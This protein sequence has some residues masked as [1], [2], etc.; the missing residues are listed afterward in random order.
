[1]TV[2][3]I[4]GYV[5][6][7]GKKDVDEEWFTSDKKE[8]EKEQR[9]LCE[10]IK[11]GDAIPKTLNHIALKALT[12]GEDGKG[13]QGV[14]ALGVLKADVDN[15]GLMMASGL[16]P[17]TFTLTRLTTLSRQLHSFFTLY[18]PHYLSSKK[19]YQ[20]I[21]TVFAGGDDLFLIGPWDNVI[22]LAISLRE[23]FAEYVC[24]NEKV[25]FSAGISFHK[26]HTPVDVMAEAAEEELEKSKSESDEKNRLT[27]FSETAAWDKVE[28]FSAIQKQL[29]RWMKDKTINKAML[30]R[31]NELME[32][33]DMENQID[34]GNIEGMDVGEL[35]CTKWRSMLAYTCVRNVADSIKGE[36][37]KEER[38]R[39]TKKVHGLLADWL[40]RHGARLKIPV[41]R[42]LYNMR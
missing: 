15:L 17:E 18:L 35:A 16:N 26:S 20:D 10:R 30:Y 2:K 40:I 25:H 23:S 28:E 41:W 21:Y 19:Q 32:M 14:D 42:I 38:K 13:F 31:L 3:H 4:N 37:R 11:K 1:M 6:V 8:D 9:K 12:P 27:L 33:A 5:P 36:S 24:G 34:L 22:D 39:V 7:Y 29:K